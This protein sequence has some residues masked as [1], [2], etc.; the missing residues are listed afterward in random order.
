MPIYAIIDEVVS[1]IAKEWSLDNLNSCADFD[2]IAKQLK[3]MYPK[4]SV[5]TV[6]VAQV[7]GILNGHDVV[8]FYDTYHPL[9]LLWSGYVE[10]VPD[11]YK[12]QFAFAMGH[13]GVAYQLYI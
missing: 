6:K 12:T 8:S 3:N 5:S 11:K 4:M 1:F 13:N 9:D 2:K 10:E 7:L